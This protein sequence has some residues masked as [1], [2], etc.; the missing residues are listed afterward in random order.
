MWRSSKTTISA[1][2]AT[3]SWLFPAYLVLINL[4]VA[5]LAIAGL[6]L[7]PDGAIDRDLTVLAL[8]LAAGARGLAL[9][10]MIGGLSAATGMVVLDS[11]ALAITISNDLV[12]PICA[13]AARQPG[14]GRRG[15]HRRA[16]PVGPAPVHC[17]RTGAG[18]PVRAA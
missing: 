5:P 10:T 2:S 13:E 15:R 18:L 17:R 14:A 7:F 12:M 3:A 11:L 6:N 16:R 4:F 1:A 9:V 8:P